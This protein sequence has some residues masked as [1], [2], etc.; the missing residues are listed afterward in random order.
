MPI[1]EVGNSVRNDTPCHSSRSISRDRIEVIDDHVTII[2]THQTNI[3]GSRGTLQILHSQTGRIERIIDSLEKQTLLRIHGLGLCRLDAEE[4]G[5]ELM[6]ILTEE[7]GITNI[8][9]IKEDQSAI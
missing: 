2:G 5:I 1:E 4:L 8:R 7:V 6:I 3:Y 9:T